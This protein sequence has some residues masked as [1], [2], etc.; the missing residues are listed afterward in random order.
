MQVEQ[1]F[2]CS[3]ERCNAKSELHQFIVDGFKKGTEILW[4]V[5]D[6]E[7]D[8]VLEVS[9]NTR[10]QVVVLKDDGDGLWPTSPTLEKQI[11]IDRQSKR[12]VAR[13]GKVIVWSFHTIDDHLAMQKITVMRRVEDVTNAAGIMSEAVSIT[14]LLDHGRVL[15]E[16]SNL[17]D[18]RDIVE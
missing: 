2:H 9:A 3:V 11:T 8:D 10:R 7:T 5:Y 17:G 12:D 13:V 18:E 1:F 4:V 16:C 14:H 6:T 15:E